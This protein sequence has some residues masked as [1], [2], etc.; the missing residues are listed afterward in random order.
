MFP[1]WGMESAYDGAAR[2]LE[3]VIAAR[4][5]QPVD[6]CGHGMER[7]PHLVLGPERILGSLNNQGRR[8]EVRQVRNPRATR[9]ARRVQRIAEQDQPPNPRQ[10]VRGI[11][12]HVRRDAPAHRL[13]PDH[14]PCGAVCCIR[15]PPS[16]VL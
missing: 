8:Y 10:R 4:H 11:R 6:R 12:Q 15:L 14:E 7:L 13:A 2:H 5:D 9:L 1:I 3:R 16:R